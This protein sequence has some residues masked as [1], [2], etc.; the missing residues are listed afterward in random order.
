MIFL[1]VFNTQLRI[2]TTMDFQNNSLIMLDSEQLLSII[3]FLDISDYSNFQRVSRYFNRMFKFTIQKRVHKSMLINCLGKEEPVNDHIEFTKSI[4]RQI[5]DNI[6]MSYLNYTASNNKLICLNN[7]QPDKFDI[8]Y[9]NR[10]Y[11]LFNKLITKQFPFEPSDVY[12]A[13]PLHKAVCKGDLTV[14]K[15]L[16]EKFPFLLNARDLFEQTALS[17]AVVYGNLD[18]VQ[19]LVTAGATLAPGRSYKHMNPVALAVYY[20]F[21]EILAYLLNGILD[22][23]FVPDIGPFTILNMYLFGLFNHVNDFNAEN[24]ITAILSPI[25][26]S[27][28]K[29]KPHAADYIKVFDQ[30]VK[31]RIRNIPVNVPGVTQVPIYL[32]NG[33]KQIDWYQSQFLIGTVTSNK[34]IDY[35]RS[36]IQNNAH[37]V[38]CISKVT[39]WLDQI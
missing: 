9:N 37:A 17:Y 25:A 30:L 34:I 15:M 12:R 10:C 11:K 33:I 32:T 23:N 21:H 19:L 3:S 8:I 20:G 36:A 28:Y 14:V 27:R 7:G 35:I 29:I 22:I 38:E 16:V 24:N 5:T 13:T 26:Y 39:N 1:H 4:L 2:Q 18:M 31:K 6:Y